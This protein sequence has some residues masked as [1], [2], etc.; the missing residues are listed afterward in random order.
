MAKILVTG[1]TGCLGS[2][3]V[4]QLA[5]QGHDVVAQ[6]RDVGLGAKL[7][8][9]N[10]T[11]LAHDLREP[12]NAQA[13]AGIEIV[14]H[15]AALSSAWGKAEV[16][17]AVNVTATQHLLNA[18]RDAGVSRFVFASSPSIYADGTH[19]L[20]VKEDAELPAHFATHYARTK[21]EA[22]VLVLASDNPAAMRTTALRPRAIYGKGDRSLMPRL[23]A[24]IG[25]GRVPMIDGGQ[26]LIDITHVS[27]AA[28]AMDC[29]ARSEAAG[30]EVFNITSGKAF[31]F[32]Q[33]LDHICAFKQCDPRRI[34]IS[35]K[36]AMRLARGLELIHR[37]VMPSRE[38]VLTCQAVASLGRSLTLD[39]SKARQLLD[40]K[41]QTEIEQGICDYA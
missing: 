32:A 35:Y 13:M 10:V 41:P 19:R 31:S 2:E 33:L 30:G 37:M 6:G 5:D 21:Y 20:N 17:Q 12:V 25:R 38:P 23:L 1:A 26:S 8:R 18:A 28:R 34:D 3:L 16:F 24:A 29:A 40:Y 36:T 22:E 7:L 15:C 39:I 11:F 27:D 4:R 9:K 14:H